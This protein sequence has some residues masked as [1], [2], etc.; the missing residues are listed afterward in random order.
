MSAVERERKKKT[1]SKSRIDG[2]LHSFA[3]VR[4]G[5]SPSRKKYYFLLFFFA[6]RKNGIRTFFFW[7]TER[8]LARS[9]SV[10]F[11]LTRN[12]PRRGKKRSPSSSFPPRRPPHFIY[13]KGAGGKTFSFFG[14]NFPSSHPRNDDARHSLV[15]PISFLSLF[16]GKIWGRVFV[17]SLPSKGKRRVAPRD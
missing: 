9:S 5:R 12:I 11:S 10:I 7:G 15:S 1:R 16:C 14:S 3:T 13:G 2:P 4:D 17:Y 6:F 8:C